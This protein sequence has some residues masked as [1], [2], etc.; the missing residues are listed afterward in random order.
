MN[1]KF[2]F[3]YNFQKGRGEYF[4]FSIPQTNHFQ[5]I[6]NLKISPEPDMIVK[7]KYNNNRVATFRL[8]DVK[9]KVKIQFAAELKTIS[10]EMNSSLTIDN[11]SN[12]TIQQFNNLLHPD[13]F[14]NGKDQKIVALATKIVGKEKRLQR[15]AS[16]LYD[17]TVKYLSYGKPIKGLYSYKQTLEDR[18]TDC[19]GFSTFLASLLQSLGIPSRLVVGYLINEDIFHKLFPN[20]FQLTTKNL[21]MHAWL[22]LI[23]PDK[24]WFPLDPSIEWRRGKRLTKRKGGFG[25]IPADR[26]ITSF[27]QDY[28]IDLDHKK[29]S[30]DLLQDPIYL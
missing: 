19:G 20:Y 8:N 16:K 13:R 14:I 3:R 18:T 15:I 9:E 27:G 25:Y 1:K 5:L 11:Y 26:I 30:A 29:Y 4:I 24:Q 17:F 21:I 10:L 12:T 7:T 6:S 28:K 23:L 2:S 22:E